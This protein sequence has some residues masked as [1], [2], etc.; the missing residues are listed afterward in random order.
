MTKNRK[1][2]NQAMAVIKPGNQIKQT[3]WWEV[4]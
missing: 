4:E 1:D 2:K 3:K